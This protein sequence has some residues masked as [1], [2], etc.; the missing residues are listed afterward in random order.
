MGLFRSGGKTKRKGRIEPQLFDSRSRGGKP[1]KRTAPRRRRTFAGYVFRFV[2]FCAFWGLIAGGAVF[3]YVWMSLDQ[4]GLLQIPDREPG[5]MVLA[6]DGTQL[7]QQGAFFGDEVSLAELPDYVPNAVIAIE[8]RRFYSHYGVDPFG[9]LRAVVTNLRSGHVVQGGSTLTQQLAKNLFLNPD[10]TMERKLQEVVLAVWLETKFSKE[11]ILQLYLNRVYYGAGAYGIEKAAQAYY[12]KSARD[13]TIAEAATLAGLLK[14]PSTYS[15]LLH[16]EAAAERSKLVINAMVETG[17]ITA[18]DAQLAIAAPAEA[19][20][21]D[22]IPATQYIADWVNDQLPE[23]VKNNKDSIVVETTIDPGLQE[24]A[25]KSLRTRLNSEG[26]KLHVSQGA[27]VMMD[28]GGAIKAMVGG[29][30]YKRSQFNRVTKAKRQP[31]SSFKPFL[32]LAALEQGYTPQSVEVDEPIQLGSWTPENY[33]QKY[34]GPVTLTT[35]L[36]Y[37]LNVIAVKLISAI[38]PDSVIEVAHRLGITSDLGRDDSLALGTSEVT[39]LEMTAA[40]VPFANGGTPVVPFAITRITTRDGHV[41]YQRQPGGMQSVISPVNLGELNSMMRAVVTEG[42]GKKA[43]FG[44]FEIAG[45]TGTSQDYRDA[46]FIGYTAQFVAGVWVGNDDNSPTTR[47][48]GGTIPTEIWHDVMAAAHQGLP[49]EPL[50]GDTS[51]PEPGDGGVMAQI[52]GEDGSGQPAVD[53]DGGGFFDGIGNLFGGGNGQ[54]RKK[55][56]NSPTAFERLNR[57]R[58]NK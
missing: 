8:D 56:G 35:A 15:P 38:G 29:K 28:T 46:W 55:S 1:Q 37:S 13:L 9:L 19:R 4:K 40:F 11:E 10:R 16:P 44:N 39:P 30:S 27:F 24:I 22:Y 18:G 34:M 52:P 45:K 48:T 43:Q 32:Y 17:A 31:G 25:E 50:P 6:D 57:T 51:Q 21:S 42:T 12:H 23:L 49:P 26:A 47:V 41:L 7:A 3:G 5:V 58:E 2:F 54:P 53:D 36:A 33:K 14:A 20:P